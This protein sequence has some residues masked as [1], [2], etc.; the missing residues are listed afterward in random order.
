MVGLIAYVAVAGF[1]G[2]FDIVAARGSLYTLNLLGQAVF[3]N[4]RDPAV[5][6]QGPIAADSA[7]MLWYNALHLALSLVIGLIVTGL[8]AHGERH[9]SRGRLVAL[10][11]VAGFV[12]T[13]VGVG[14]FTG[15]LRELL[16]WWSIVVANSLSV[17]LASWYLVRRYPG[18]WG[19]L[20]ASGAGAA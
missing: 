6:Q 4:L 5:L 17:V 19:R 15:P 3:R 16:P 20:M 18:I 14:M 12:V 9:P 13:I 8:V 10:I 2:A 11:I 1:Y 7:A